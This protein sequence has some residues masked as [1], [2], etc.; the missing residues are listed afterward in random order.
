VERV[1][2]YDVAGVLGKSQE[3]ILLREDMQ[4]DLVRLIF[5]R[6]QAATKR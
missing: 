6:L 1:Y 3:E 4:R 2:Q 5:Y